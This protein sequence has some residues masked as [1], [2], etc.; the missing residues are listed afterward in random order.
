MS[1][2]KKEDKKKSEDIVNNVEETIPDLPEIFRHEKKE[3]TEEIASIPKVKIEKKEKE[4]VEET[5][6]SN[7]FSQKIQGLKEKVEQI[8]N[9][10]KLRPQIEKDIENLLKDGNT[11]LIG[12]NVGVFAERLT[13]KGM[14][15]I[16]RDTSITFISPKTE[17]N[18]VK[19]LEK[20]ELKPFSLE[21]MNNLKGPFI[22]IILFFALKGR[23]KEEI[24][25]IVNKC[26]Q[27]LYS[28][29]LLFIVEESASGL[30]IFLNFFKYLTYVNKF[31]KSKIKKE[32]YTWPVVKIKK[33]I[34]QLELR[35]FKTFVYG[36]RNVQTYVLAKRLSAF[37]SK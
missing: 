19:I 22:N 25:S 32:E 30:N 23:K 24:Y 2:N 28:S 11:L 10:N 29:G 20:M 31:I 36:G 15:V 21:K 17:V 6:S 4:Q 27:L 33:V 9:V 5:K 26:K 37:L 34:K 12:K 35:K 8:V 18:N 7:L 14:N 1:K 3:E 16:A 13:E